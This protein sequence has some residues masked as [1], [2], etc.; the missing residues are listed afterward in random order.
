MYN[1][2]LSH[3]LCFFCENRVWARPD[4]LDKVDYALSVTPALEN[5]LRKEFD[6]AY[7]LT[8]LGK[9]YIIS[10][11]DKTWIIGHRAFP[12]RSEASIPPKISGAAFPQSHRQ[13]P[14]YF[15]FSLFPPYTFPS[16]TPYHCVTIASTY[17]VLFDVARSTK[18]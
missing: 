10:A 18:S 16:A 13:S 2:I 3:E 12:F 6:I 1:C 14:F 7:P 5:Y 9:W 8:K 4:R 15:N 17:N 11:S